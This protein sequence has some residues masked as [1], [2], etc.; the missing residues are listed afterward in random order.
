MVYPIGLPRPEE[1]IQIKSK[2]KQLERIMCAENNADCNKVVV[3][4]NNELPRYLWDQWS[5]ELKKWGYDWQRFL[6]VLKLVTGDIILWA[7]KDSLTWDE[8]V[9]RISD[10]LRAYSGGGVVGLR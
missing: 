3:W 1:P 8:L 9:K 2:I 6:K 10:V 5:A 7:L 4:S